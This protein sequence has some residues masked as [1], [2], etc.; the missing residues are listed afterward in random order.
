MVAAL[1]MARHGL[2]SRR[3]CP[4]GLAYWPGWSAEFPNGT[5]LASARRSTATAPA[6]AVSAAPAR[7]IFRHLTPTNATRLL[8][9]RDDQ[10]LADVH[11]PH[12]RLAREGLSNPEIGARLFISARTVQYHLGKVFTKLAISSR[13]RGLGIRSA[14]GARSLGR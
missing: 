2:V 6:G 9:G 14:C 8:T 4:A 10:P 12:R 1:L 3:G 13:S 11:A 5:R 7:G